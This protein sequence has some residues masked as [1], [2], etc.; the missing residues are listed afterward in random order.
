[1]KHQKDHQKKLGAFYHDVQVRLQFLLTTSLTNA[2]G[3]C[4]CI[5][6]EFSDEIFCFDHASSLRV[7]FQ[8]ASQDSCSN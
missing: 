3:R 7:Y 5:L 2:K 6:P 4:V 8:M 1:M